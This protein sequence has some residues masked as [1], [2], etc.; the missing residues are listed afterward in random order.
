MLGIHA[1]HGQR[2]TLP[3]LWTLAV[4]PGAILSFDLTWLIA[5]TLNAL[6]AIPNLI[7][8]LLRPVKQKYTK[9]CIFEA[10]IK[11]SGNSYDNRH[12]PHIS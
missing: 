2:K 11:I 5:D 6:T 1:R 3:H 9:A 7:S 12:T 8:L 10:A 4:F